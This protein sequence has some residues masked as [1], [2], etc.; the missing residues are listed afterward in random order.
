MLT[1]TIER[2]SASCRETAGQNLKV[3]PVL[4]CSL[5]ADD[6]LPGVRSRRYRIAKSGF[7]RMCALALLTAS[8]VPAMFIAAAIVI[9][10]KGPVFY[11]EVRTGQGGRPF[12]IWKFRSMQA[13]RPAEMTDADCLLLRIEKSPND[14]RITRV[15]GFLRRWSLDELPQ[16]LNVMCGDMSLVGP[17]PVIHREIE[18]YGEHRPSYLAAKPGLSGLWQISGRSNVDFETRVQLDVAYLQTW[19]FRNDLRIIWKTLPVVLRRT[20]AR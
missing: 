13:T 16:L 10:S 14:P 12:E 8:V 9:E 2:T 15:G 19:S 6:H 1:G 20:G 17:R 7:D 18:L 11:R 3:D 5:N 4:F